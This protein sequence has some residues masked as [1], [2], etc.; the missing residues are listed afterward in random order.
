[1]S[2]DQGLVVVAKRP[3]VDVTRK[4]DSR[5]TELGREMQLQ[6]DTVVLGKPAGEC[7]AEEPDD[8]A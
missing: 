6:V 2:V 3:T 7:I 1:M 5:M 8:S 4:L